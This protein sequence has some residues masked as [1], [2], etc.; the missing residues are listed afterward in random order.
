MNQTDSK[1]GGFHYGWIIVVVSTLALVI[2]NG[3]STTGIPVFYKPMREEFVALGAVSPAY[4]E[5]FVANGAYLTFLMSGVFSL[6]GGW[7]ALKFDLRNLMIFGCILLGGG[8]LIHSQTASP[9]MIYFS[10]FLMGASLG[11]VGVTPNVLLV[12]NWFARRRGT[13]LGIVLTGTS[14][15]GVFVPLIAAPLIASHGWRT[16]MFFV[17]LIVWLVLLPAIL[18]LVKNKPENELRITN[19]ELRNEVVS[20][21][22]TDSSIQNPKSKTQNHDLT[23]RQALRTSIFWIFAFCAAAVFYAIFAVSQQLNLYLQSPKIGFSAQQAA[24]AQS[25]LFALSVAGKFLFGFLSD[26]FS[27]TRVM[28]V[29]ALAMFL[30]TLTFLHFNE[31]SAYFFVVLFGL[32]YGGTFVLLQRLVTD[33]FGTREYGKILGVITLIETVGAAIGGF[34]TGRLA[35]AASGDY[36]QAFYAVILTT[37]AAFVAVVVLNL[38]TGKK[39]FSKQN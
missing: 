36:T 38:M 30:S 4:A 20:E 23:L 10:R 15:G 33:Y 32:T 16:A 29:S 17:S 2:T 1:T 34:V 8:L 9:E 13:A 28:L 25:L 18:F 19:Y 37:G 22:E 31:Q 7:L 21:S 35:D 3:L 24:F 39:G 12:S 14:F 5:S 11:F 6:V 27:S 26:V